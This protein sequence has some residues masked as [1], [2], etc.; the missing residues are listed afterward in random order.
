MKIRYKFRTLL[1][2]MAVV[3][4]YVALQLHITSKACRFAELMRK[5][6]IETQER[7]LKDTDSEVELDYLWGPGDNERGHAL[8]APLTFTD[9]MLLRR[10]CEV[11]FAT[12]YLLQDVRIER[13]YTH[14]Y[15]TSCFGQSC[16]SEFAYTSI[17]AVKRAW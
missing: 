4:S 13:E 15:R 17:H 3:G 2:F 7:L 10:R 8:V 11:T 5:P 9:V 1:V 14:I 12:I 16:E 6:T